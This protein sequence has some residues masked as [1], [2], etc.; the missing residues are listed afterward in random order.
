MSN[1]IKKKMKA[2]IFAAGLG[3]RL[4]PLTLN[5]PKA[6][7]EI[8][9][10]TLLELAIRK[11]IDHG[12]TDIII[13]VHAFGNQIIEFVNQHYFEARISI[14]DEQDLLLDTGG[15]LIKAL[16]FFSDG[17]PFLVYNVDI[18]TTV[19]LRGFYEQ[20]L[21][22]KPLASLMVRKRSSSRYLLFD[23]EMNLSGWRNISN[24]E[25][26]W[27]NDA[28]ATTEEFAF[29]GIHI[30]DP[31]ISKYIKTENTPFPIVPFYLE[32]AKHEPI[33]GVVDKDSVWFDVGKL[34]Q[35]K[36]AE[37]FLSNGR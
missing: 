31:R 29:S 34:E 18:I 12:F 15:G 13:N 5:K 27:V 4:Q 7:V 36:E 30:V 1:F 20:H 19:D 11:L 21:I 14:S 6:L 24:G 8:N 35:L 2:I 37:K 3:T 10:I 16:P 33:K 23:R 26:I 25:E 17:A 32:V 22:Q 9:G 28:E